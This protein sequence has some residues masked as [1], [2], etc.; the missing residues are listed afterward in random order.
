MYIFGVLQVD[1]SPEAAAHNDRWLGPMTMGV[2]VTKLP[3]AK[4]CGLGNND[5]QHS[6]TRTSSAMEQSLVDRLPPLG[7]KLVTIKLDKDSVV[8]MAIYDLRAKKLDA[9]INKVLV[10][11]AGA[12]DRHGWRE[13][14]KRSPALAT[15]FTGSKAVTALDAVATNHEKWP[16]LDEKVRVSA[17]IITGQ[18]GENDIRNIAGHMP[19]KRTSDFEFDLHAGSMVGFIRAPGAYH[20]ARGWA[21]NRFPVAIVFDPEYEYL[22]ER[23]RRFTVVWQSEMAGREEFEE[24]VN[25]LEMKVRGMTYEELVSN[26]MSW[27]GNPAIVSSPEGKGVQTLLFEKQVLE[28]AL[29]CSRLAPT[30]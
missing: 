5:P 22:G 9:K 27:G 30:R 19:G 10:A 8:A 23:C 1:N 24:M 20:Q 2:E 18:L 15:Y 6:G 28:L 11:W 29:E 26:L 16:T 4:R 13:A 21:N 12:V 25:A 17:L 3:L 7:A 14:Q